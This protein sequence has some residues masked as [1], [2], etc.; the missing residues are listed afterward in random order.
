MNKK[1]LAEEILRAYQA[2]S[3]SLLS[4]TSGSSW[5]F[6]T[7]TMQQDLNAALQSWFEK[8]DPSLLIGI[9]QMF[10]T[11]NVITPAVADA[12]LQTLESEHVT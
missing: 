10:L 7:P 1:A 12:W 4:N 8:D 9:V 6:Q 5:A 3:S 2:Q 11:M